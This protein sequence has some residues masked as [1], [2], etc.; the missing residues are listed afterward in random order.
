MVAEG[1]K[2]EAGELGGIDWSFRVGVRRG[3]A[4]EECKGDSVSTSG[5]RLAWLE[6]ERTDLFDSTAMPSND[7]VTGGRTGRRQL[8]K[9]SKGEKVGAVLLKAGKEGK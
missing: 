4:E 7:S 8:A 1:G 5:A 9:A 6:G 3:R 2:G